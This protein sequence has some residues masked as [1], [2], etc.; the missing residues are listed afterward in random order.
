[1]DQTLTIYTTQ[2][3]GYCIRLK[4]QLA[5][6]GIGFI[7]VD[8]ESDPRA[9]ELVEYINGGWRLVPTV[10]FA[11]GEAIGNPSLAEVKEQ[12]AKLTD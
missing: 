12:L 5:G 8:V 11:D 2:W 1:M 10:V 7:E 3:C 4:R 6:E 9:A